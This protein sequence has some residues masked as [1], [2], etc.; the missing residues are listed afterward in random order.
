MKLKTLSLCLLIFGSGFYAGSWW[1]SPPQTPNSVI[2]QK[3]ITPKPQ[4]PQQPSTIAPP[5][6]LPQASSPQAQEEPTKQVQPSQKIAE[7]IQQKPQNQSMVDWLSDVPFV[8]DFMPATLIDYMLLNL[9]VVEPEVL[10][11]IP[12]S[13]KFIKKLWKIAI[14]PQ[15]DKSI[16]FRQE[17]FS[18][19]IFPVD[20]SK[21]SGLGKSSV[22]VQSSFFPGKYKIFGH[23]QLFQEDIEYVLAHWYNKDTNKN[24]FL[25]V[26]PVVLGEKNFL[27]SEHSW[28]TGNYVLALSSFP[29]L[30]LIAYGE[31]QIE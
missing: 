23:F 21:Y 14:L 29:E 12:D 13:Q 1:S 20:F 10:E 26:Y 6:D 7:K 16:D 19:I 5:Q 30:E 18:G 22:I 25:G 4:E 24:I 15:L 8:L 27:W 2:A 11:T 3:P 28:R 31:Y 17:Y 9:I